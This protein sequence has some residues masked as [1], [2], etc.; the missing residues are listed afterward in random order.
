MYL[1]DEEVLGLV[2]NALK[3]LKTGGYIFFRESCFHASGN[4]KASNEN[5]T[6]YRSPTKYIDFFQSKVLEE[7]GEQYGFELVFARPSRTY[8]EV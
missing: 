2:S 3:T 6:E 4:I 5:P 8:I 7:N 1:S